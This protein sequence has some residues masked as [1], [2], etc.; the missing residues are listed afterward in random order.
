MKR[1]LRGGEAN[2]LAPQFSFLGRAFL[3]AWWQLHA[4]RLHPLC[5]A[6]MRG[7][8][9]KVVAMPGMEKASCITGT[10]V[11]RWY[12]GNKFGMGAGA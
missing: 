3:L 11:T 1:S 4:R 6:I 8:L 10:I 5:H 9:F 7:M 12:P 2:S